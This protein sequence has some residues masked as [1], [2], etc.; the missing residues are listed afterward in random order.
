M[1]REH[2]SIISEQIIP[3]SKALKPD[4]SMHSFG[5]NFN[6]ESLLDLPLPNVPNR[7]KQWHWAN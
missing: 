2:A 1:N 5:S 3:G 4:V 6:I 7:E